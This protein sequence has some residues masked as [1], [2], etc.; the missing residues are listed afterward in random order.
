MTEKVECIVIGAGVVGLAIAARLAAAGREVVVLE[1]HGSIGS[2][3]SSRNSEVI[4]AGIYYPHGSRKA[5]L[6][7]RGKALLYRHCDVFGVPYK[8]CGKVIVATSDQQ[9][10]IVDGYIEQA[11]ANGVDDLRWINQSELNALEPEV[12]GV[13]AALSPSTGIVD[14]HSYMISLQGIVEANG[15]FVAL[16]SEVLGIEHGDK[17][18]VRTKQMTLV[19]DW[20]INAG[21]LQAPMLAHNIP[22]TPSAHYAIGHY[23]TYSGAQPFGRLVYPTAQEGGLGVHVTLDLGGQVKFGP[24]VRW[25]D[26]V[27]YTFDDSKR[28]EFI[29]AIRAYYPGLD[30]ARLQ[31]G[32]TGIRPKIAGAG[33]SSDFL[34]R[35]PQD[36]GVAGRVDLLGIESPGLT[37]SLAIAEDVGE[38][39]ACG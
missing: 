8:R 22:G 19:A 29:D 32:Y 9:R 13:G 7:V 15:G 26:D 16:Q 25:V 6:C 14:S 30:E 35:G 33:V 17:P 38:V 5:A 31:P 37:A 23:Y 18:T 20:V 12:A 3:T 36:H 24:D 28:E 1:R 2:E 10:P 39:L 4:H 11:L 34:I 27:D 21:G